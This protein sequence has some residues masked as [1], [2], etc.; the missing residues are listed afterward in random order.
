MMMNK[1]R[2]M[3]G[4]DDKTHWRARLAPHICM[5]TVLALNIAFYAKSA[6]TLRLVELTVC[7]EY[8]AEH[9]PGKIGD[10]G[11]V[12]ERECKMADVQKKVAWLFMA[13]E[14]L[15]F[16][17]GELESIHTVRDEIIGSLRA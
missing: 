11:F 5:A 8:Y 10:G 9:D 15:H 17:C 13:D 7:R 4:A 14:L 12:D 3:F 16:V 2:R 6:P 1:V